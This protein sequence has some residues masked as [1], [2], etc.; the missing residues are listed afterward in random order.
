MSSKVQ[1]LDRRME[2][3]IAITI[4]DRKRP[5]WNCPKLKSKDG[6]F[7]GPTMIV[8]AVRSFEMK[9]RPIPMP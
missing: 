5:T 4:I 2:T 6:S 1:I 7:M 9:N 8:K 3:I